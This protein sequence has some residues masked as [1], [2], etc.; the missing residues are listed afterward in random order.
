MKNFIL[1]IAYV[2]ISLASLAQGDSLSDH[3]KGFF[4]RTFHRDEY[5]KNIIRYNP[6]PTVIFENG[7]NAAIG[8]ERVLGHN[9]SVSANFGFFFL[10]GFLTSENGFY[11]IKRNSESG[12]ITSVDYRFYLK[13]H[14]TRPAPNG[15]YLGPYFSW[16]N[17][18]GDVT[19]TYADNSGS[20]NTDMRT[21]FNLYNFGFQLGY[22]FVFYKRITLDMVLCGPSLSFYD[23]QMDLAT[24]IPPEK[25]VEIREKYYSRFF[26]RYPLFQEL[27]KNGHVESKGASTGI[28]PGFRYLFQVGYSF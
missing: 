24:T 7:K 21:K 25:A 26:S 22:Q 17:H 3:K 12:F 9:Q 6:M 2:F 27:F 13:K 15:I 11:N 4:Y 18:K 10:P 23:V 28:I 14:N 8:Y 1:L 5:G 16:Y 19:V 20:Y